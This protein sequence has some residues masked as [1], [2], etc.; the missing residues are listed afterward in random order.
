M[1]AA[2]PEGH[3][4]K[5]GLLAQELVPQQQRLQREECTATAAGHRVSS[6]GSRPADDTGRRP[7]VPAGV[8]PM[9]NKHGNGVLS[10]GFQRQL[11]VVPPVLK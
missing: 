9:I 4:A 3:R 2:A 5:E 10:Y 6:G 7:K 1:T 8:G 11:R